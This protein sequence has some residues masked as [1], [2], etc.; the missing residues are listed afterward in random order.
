MSSLS[1][2]Y[3]NYNKAVQ[4]AGQLDDVARQLKQAADRDMEGILNDVYRVWKSDSAPQYIQ[5]GQ[6]VQGDIGTA[7]KNLSQIAKAIR[8]I[9]Q[10]VRDAELEAWRIANERNS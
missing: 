9:A 5:K 7:S 10:R 4:Q 1:E 6:K 8:T 2:I 3:F